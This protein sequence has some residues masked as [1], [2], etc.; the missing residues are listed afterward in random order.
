MPHIGIVCQG[1][2]A[3][4]DLATLSRYRVE[5]F[6]FFNFYIL[7]TDMQPQREG[8]DEPEPTGHP[9][10]RRVSAQSECVN[11]HSM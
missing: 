8:Y 5:G 3:Q 10:C 7:I 2:K 4:R 6:L 1:R 9:G 11:Q